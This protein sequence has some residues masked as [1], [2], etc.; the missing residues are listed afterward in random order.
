MTRLAGAMPTRVSIRIAGL[1]LA[2]L[3]AG[4]VSPPVPGAA[5]DDR[6][7]YV[8]G[9][10]WHTDIALRVE[11]IAGPLAVL[12][13]HFPGVRML[14]FGFGER[15]FLINRETSLITMLAALLPS[16]SALL[17][18]ALRASPEQAFGAQHVVAIRVSRA[19]LERIEAAIWREFEQTPPA[20]PIRLA[21][22]PYAGSVFY[23]AT[24][25]YD[26]FFTCNTWTAETLEAGGL[27]VAATGVLFAS[28]VMGAARWIRSQQAV[29]P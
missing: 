21:D 5:S 7:V 12:E 13:Q 26:G 23:A 3:V 24:G 25:T 20:E 22:G 1:A 4:C 16:R 18:T 10:E 15:Q 9:R 19:G 17:V 29:A 11:D 14:T 2:L 28:Q 27:P 8:I 6:I